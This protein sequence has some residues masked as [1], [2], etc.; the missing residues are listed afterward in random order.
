MK[1]LFVLS[2]SPHKYQGAGGR[3]RIVHELKEVL[4]G[5][6]NA[7]LF[8]LVHLKHYRNI[9]ALSHSRKMLAKDCGVKVVYFPS[10]PSLNGKIYF[11][12]NF[13]DSV[14][15]WIYLKM[16]GCHSVHAHGISAA[17]PVV[18]IKSFDKSI[19]LLTDV[20]GAIPEEYSYSQSNPDP[21]EFKRL[22]DLE[23]NVLLHS[24]LL[25]LVSNRLKE[26]YV[27]KYGIGL[28]NSALVPCLTNEIPVK[29]PRQVS[30]PEKIKDIGTD[31]IIFTYS[32]SYRKYQLIDETFHLF[33]KIKERIPKAF[34]LV[35]TNQ[36]E[37]FAKKAAETGISS[38]DFKI[39]SLNRDEVPVYL[40][41]ADIA[42]LLRD[43]SVVNTV[44][45]PT[46]FAEYLLAGLPVIT[47][48]FVGDY[49]E[50]VN[51]H[52]IGYTVHDM[53]EPEQGLFDFIQNYTDNKESYKTRTTEYASNNLTW[54]ANLEFLLDT[55]KKY[56]FI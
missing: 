37:I 22:S 23:K 39:I 49:S 48:D 50:F 47:T 15:V 5:Q 6:V 11:L 36:V 53:K 18:S 10:L 27:N 41:Q 20:H 19:S 44:A 4:A 28:G 38:D 34:F 21:N 54:T 46:K 26:H 52:H 17:V 24:D 2:N 31:R 1:K 9:S 55:G 51:A 14:A 8:C 3:T 43:N 13:F 45:S 25:F 32:G 16:W 12:S 35:M 33:L 56:G 40:Q 30:R 42:F 29:T 7:R